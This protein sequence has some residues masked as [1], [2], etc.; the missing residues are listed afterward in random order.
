[1]GS[2]VFLSFFFLEKWFKYDSEFYNGADLYVLPSLAHIEGDT[3]PPNN[4]CLLIFNVP[5]HHMF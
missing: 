5:I 2:L 1:M 3:Q 4:V